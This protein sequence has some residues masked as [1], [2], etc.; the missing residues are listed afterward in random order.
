MN[1][2]PNRFAAVGL[3]PRSGI[4]A[5]CLIVAVACAS[6]D[7]GTAPVEPEG[8]FV[9]TGGTGHPPVTMSSMKDL[10]SGSVTTLEYDEVKYDIGLRDDI[11]TERYLRRPPREYLR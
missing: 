11:F 7:D 2:N 1:E 5:A 8:V 4:I 3:L 6:A 9:A 10:R